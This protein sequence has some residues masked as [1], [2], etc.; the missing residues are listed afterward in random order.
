MSN[1]AAGIY[2]IKKIFCRQNAKD[3]LQ[4]DNLLI[5]PLIII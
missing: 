1:A 3:F 4:Y 5:K 2:L